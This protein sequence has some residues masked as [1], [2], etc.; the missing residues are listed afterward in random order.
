MTVV[1]VVLLALLDGRWPGGRP[2]RGRD[3]LDRNIMPALLE[4]VRGLRQAME[5]MS[6]AG[7][8]GPAGARP[9]PT[10][11]AA[12]QQRDQAGGRRAQPA[13][14]NCSGNPRPERSQQ[15]KRVGRAKLRE[16]GTRVGGDGP[17]PEQLAGVI[18]HHK[19]QLA[20]H[21]AETAAGRRRGGHVRHRGR[22]RAGAL[23]RDQP[24]ARGSR[25]SPASADHVK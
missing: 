3:E 13:R 15:M 5:Q 10:P 6:S 1:A 23:D 4:E 17:T 16:R 24:A 21:S 22:D 12:D 11:G 8:P 18:Q 19:Q 20:N 9:A 25:A 14:S 2:R 7:C